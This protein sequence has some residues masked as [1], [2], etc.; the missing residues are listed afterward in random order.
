[1][2]H[3]VKNPTKANKT[4]FEKTV[5][6]N[7][8]TQAKDVCNIDFLA[9]LDGNL[10]RIGDTVML[11]NCEYYII[12]FKR[13]LNDM[14]AEYKKYK[15]SSIGFLKARHNLIKRKQHVAHYLIGGELSENETLQ[16]KII[17]YFNLP[18]STEKFGKDY[19]ELRGDKYDEKKLSALIECMNN[20]STLKAGTIHA[21]AKG[22]QLNAGMTQAELREYTLELT[23]H[24]VS[25]SDDKAG[26]DGAVHTC[27]IAVPTRPKADDTEHNDNIQHKQVAAQIVTLDY[28]QKYVFDPKPARKLGFSGGRSRK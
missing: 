7:F 13:S 16:L 4:W 24:R 17:E 3:P 27:V 23:S 6:Y 18:P 1:M 10:E 15:N 12:E 9:P 19:K 26:G 22:F 2:N 25:K 5:E 14:S 8:V 21:F 28:Y 20:D 11:A